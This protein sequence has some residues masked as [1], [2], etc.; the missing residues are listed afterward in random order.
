MVCD[1][2]KNTIPKAVVHCQVREAKRSLLNHFYV[3]VGRKEVRLFIFGLN[4]PHL[5][6]NILSFLNYIIFM[7][8]AQVIITCLIWI[9]SCNYNAMPLLSIDNLMNLVQVWE[10]TKW[11]FFC[12]YHEVHVTKAV[13]DEFK[14]TVGLSF[15]KLQKYDAIS[16]WLW[17]WGW[18]GLDSVLVRH[19]CGFVF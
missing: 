11:F 3:Q 16:Y 4:F 9:Y 17:V 2:L 7:V 14:Y 8:S 1:T 12:Q 19:P 5:R 13:Y 6:Y 18:S 15:W 10:L